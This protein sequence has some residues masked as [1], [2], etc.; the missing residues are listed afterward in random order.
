MGGAAMSLTGGTL[1]TAG[2]ATATHCGG[3]ALRSAV[4][5]VSHESMSSQASTVT[6]LGCVVIRRLRNAF[7]CVVFGLDMP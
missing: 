6:D 7:G 4:R 5:S 1:T 2:T 3:S